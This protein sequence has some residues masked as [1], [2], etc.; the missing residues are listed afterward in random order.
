MEVPFF[1]ALRQHVAL[2]KELESAFARF[3]QQGTFIL[4]KEVKMFEDAYAHF[5][6]MPFCTSVA[7]GLDAIF[8]SL[9]SLHIGPGD[10]VL[11]PSH[12][13]FATW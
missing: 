10:E 9:K 5:H 6:D 13:C 12:T 3:F 11:V 7:N 1:S 4:G 8:I 2:Q